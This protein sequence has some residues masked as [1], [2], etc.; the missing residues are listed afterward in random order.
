MTEQPNAGAP[1]VVI[2]AS[3]AF[4][5]IMSF[6]G[7][8]ADHIIPDKTHVISVSFLVDTLRKQRGGCGGNVAYSLALL[9]TSSSLVGAVGHDFA[10]YREAMERLGIDLSAVIQDSNQATATAF[11]MA[12]RKDNQINS[13]YPGPSDRAIE[14]DLTELGNKAT[15]GLVGPT[16]PTVMCAHAAQLGAAGCR[17]IYD[18]AF[19]IIILSAEELIAGID[20]AWALIGNDYEYAMIERKTGLSI[21]MLESR[22]ELLV[23]TYGDQGSELRQGGR[24][25]RV[26]AAQAAV[27]RDPSGAG[28]AYRS[29]LLKGLLLDLDLDVM[30]RMAGLAAT[31]VV[32]QVG[33]QEHTYTAGEFVQRFDEVF[34]EYRGAIALEKLT[35]SG[36]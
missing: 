23:V 35:P 26:P 7:S 4:D 36:R 30:G 1:P 10:Q 33:P 31:Y 15:F 29:G 28:D 34:P 20:A 5:Y 24:R 8:F 32:E 19:Q 14:I 12:D 6:G 13:F 27:V 22:V 9:G 11:M 17:M 21:D 18:P 3:I 16:G 2:S 25:V